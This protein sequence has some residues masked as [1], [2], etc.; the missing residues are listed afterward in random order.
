VPLAIA[1]FLAPESPW[2]LVRKGRFEEAERSLS[3]LVAAPRD[4]I[5]PKDTLSLIIRTVEGERAHQIQGSYFECFKG[6]N[7][8]RTE[9]AMVSWGCQIL[10][11]ALRL[12]GDLASVTV[13]AAY[14][15]L[16]LIIQSYITYFFTLAGLKTADSFYL[17]IGEDSRVS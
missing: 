1:T 15:S 3:R 10:P 9:I 14:F 7:L 12:G 13:A 17:S 8:R 5:D 2:W 6:T 4:I 11:G 16:G